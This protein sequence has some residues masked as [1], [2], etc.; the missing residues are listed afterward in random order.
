MKITTDMQRLLTRQN[1]V[2]V[3]TVNPDDSPNISLKGLLK[4]DPE[5]CIYFSD[6]YRGKTFRNIRRNPRVSVLV[7]SIEE[8]RGFQFIGRAELIESG[9]LFKEAEADWQAKKSRLLGRRISK[10]VRKGFSHG[11]SEF[12]LPS[13]KALIRMD[14]ERVYD[15]SP[16]RSREADEAGT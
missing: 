3:G 14:V 13:L 7:F 8:F 11:R 1:V 6:L 12:Q 16:D 10:N 15:M 2:I 9:P 5:G 4:V